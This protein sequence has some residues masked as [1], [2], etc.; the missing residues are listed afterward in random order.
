MSDNDDYD[1]DN[2]SLS[3]FLS[4]AALRPSE[5][6]GCSIA[7]HVLTWNRHCPTHTNLL[8]QSR[9]SFLMVNRTSHAVCVMSVI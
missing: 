3:L 5:I 1:D 7:S 8:S 6:R 4:H 2:S 9:G